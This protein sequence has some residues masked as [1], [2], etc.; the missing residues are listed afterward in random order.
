MLSHLQIVAV[1]DTKQ[2]VVCQ[3]IT[4]SQ[5]VFILLVI[6]WWCKKTWYNKITRFRKPT[7]KTLTFWLGFQAQQARIKVFAHHQLG[8]LRLTGQFSNVLRTEEDVVVQVVVSEDTLGEFHHFGHLPH[9]GSTV[10][11]DALK[12]CEFNKR[13]KNWTLTHHLGHGWTWIIYWNRC[14]SG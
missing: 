10:G 1:V 4:Y 14:H 3:T 9:F 5:T 7:S 6:G 8:S 13:L 11:F 12:R 2:L